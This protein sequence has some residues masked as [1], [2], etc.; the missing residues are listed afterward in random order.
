MFRPLVG[1]LQILGLCSLVSLQAQAEVS[2]PIP[3][4][5]EKVRID[6]RMAQAS[7]PETINTRVQDIDRLSWRMPESGKPGLAPPNH[8]VW[9]RTRLDNAGAEAQ[10]LSLQALDTHLQ[11]FKAYWL[12]DSGTPVTVWD[13]AQQGHPSQQP[14]FDSRLATAL[15]LPAQSGGELL[16]RVQGAGSGPSPLFLQQSDAYERDR[17]WRLIGLGSFFGLLTF[18]TLCS[19]VLYLCTRYT[20][21]LFYALL[22][23]LVSGF[24]FF[25][26]GLAYASPWFD[27]PDQVYRLLVLTTVLPLALASGYPV[28]RACHRQQSIRENGLWLLLMLLIAAV[29][30]FVGAMTP[31]YLGLLGPAVVLTGLVT[32]TLAGHSAWLAWHHGVSSQ[33]LV[34]IGWLTYF[35]GVTA[36]TASHLGWVSDSAFTGGGVYIGAVTTLTLLTLAYVYH[37][38]QERG[39]RVI[40][41]QQTLDA[42]GKF[43]RLYMNAEEG[44]A[45]LSEA[46]HILDANPAFCRLL[47]YKDL[48]TL[49]LRMHDNITRYTDAME[50]QSLRS[51][52]FTYGKAR[53]REVELVTDSGKSLSVLVMAWLEN[54]EQR[55]VIKCSFVDITGRKAYEQRLAHLATHDSLTGLSTREALLDELR[56]H[57]DRQIYSGRCMAILYLNLDNFRLINE[58]GGQQNGNEALLQ[59]T[60]IL[61]AEFGADHTVARTG[62][63]EFAVLQVDTQRESIQQSAERVRLALKESDFSFR[64]QSHRLSASIGITLFYPENQLAD[65]LLSQADTACLTAKDLGGNQIS[66][67]AETDADMQ[68]RHTL[69][70]WASEIYQALNEDRFV[71]YRQP[72]QSFQGDEPGQHYE[73]LLRLRLADGRLAPPSEFMPAG[74]RYA[75][76]EA[77]DRWVVQHF[78]RWLETHPTELATLHRAS[79]NLSGQSLNAQEFVPFVEEQFMQSGIPYDRICFEITESMAVKRVD[80]T[81]QFID[82]LSTL[83]CQ[84]SL[85]DFGSGYSSYSHL[86]HLPVH[87][88]KIDGGFVRHM[89]T[90]PSDRAM[91]K[92]IHEVADSM[93]IKTIAEFVENEAISAALQAMGI[94]FGQGY[95]LGKPEPLGWS[96][97]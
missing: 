60:E 46:G 67:Y 78:F 34:A 43:E 48:H 82:R 41:Q 74:E 64:G 92:S 59:V 49:R 76:M 38:R 11:D 75:L 25:F 96:Q 15:E 21:Y 29:T 50:F 58:Q 37:L 4:G 39:R 22:G 23:A 32:L 19:L 47:G 1:F 57:V 36:T 42:L 18:I 10:S 28:Y 27:S 91:V 33:W 56:R 26:S 7:G 81:Q 20:T 93:H 5:A 6:H 71:L 55:P 68:R 89:L 35:S 51:Q 54:D 85:D 97:S 40:A 77:V 2:L 72:I 69:S 30:L 14:A 88:L 24:F 8:P 63:D 65:D 53:D 45:T 61:M 17:T 3:S 52:V 80:I 12:P 62:A 83:G 90:T 31:H 87:Y 70:S 9:F 86:K 79:V 94:H 73:V 95:G 16:V 66:F 84:F 44:F 13:V